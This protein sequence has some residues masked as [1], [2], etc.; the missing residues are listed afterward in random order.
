MEKEVEVLE[1]A[2]ELP[3][4]IWLTTS[5]GIQVS[6]DE[7]L[8]VVTQDDWGLLKGL[9]V[10]VEAG[11]HIGVQDR[12]IEEPGPPPTESLDLR[13]PIGLARHGEGP[14]RQPRRRVGDVE[15]GL[16]PME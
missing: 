11:K 9:G 2:A 14:G 15:T 16:S 1:P 8:Q 4:R 13:H 7:A 3:L 12:L 5:M 10:G 6:R